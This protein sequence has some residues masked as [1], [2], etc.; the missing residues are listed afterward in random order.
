MRELQ[1]VLAPGGSLLFAVPV[2]QAVIRFNAHRIY[3]QGQV[4]AGFPELSLREFTLI[5]DRAA[6]GHLW[7]NAPAAEADRQRYGCGCF[8]F[9]RREGAI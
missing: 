1:R 5:P 4:L 8:W 6:Q 2:G 9:Q 3:S 7:R